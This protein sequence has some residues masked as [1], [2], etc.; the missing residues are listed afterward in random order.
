MSSN[1]VHGFMAYVDGNL[2]AVR[3]AFDDAKTAAEEHLTMSSPT[4]SF[5]IR[6]ATSDVFA[7]RGYVGASPMRTWN[8]DRKLKQWVEFLR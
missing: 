2:V 5:Q 6:S 4:A 3:D 7:G 1:L 8:Y